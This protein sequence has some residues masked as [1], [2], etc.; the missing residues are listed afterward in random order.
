MSTTK[1]S[2]QKPP[3]QQNCYVVSFQVHNLEKKNDVESLLENLNKHLQDSNFLI[4]FASEPKDPDYFKAV[5]VPN[6]LSLHF[7]LDAP[8]HFEKQKDLLRAWHVLVEKGSTE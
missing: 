3:Q 6:S 8:L 1:I 7:S 5:Y 4:N 2:E